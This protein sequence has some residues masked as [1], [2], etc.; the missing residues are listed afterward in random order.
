MSNTCFQPLV[1]VSATNWFVALGP[2]YLNSILI[3]PP[4]HMAGF[5]AQYSAASFFA[6]S[7]SSASCFTF[8]LLYLLCLMNMLSAGVRMPC[9]MISR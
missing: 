5:S 7:G 4:W 6:P 1:K 8:G 3:L 2:V 9:P